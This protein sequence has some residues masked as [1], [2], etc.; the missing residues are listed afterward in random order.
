MESV[1]WSNNVER[2]VKGGVNESKQG[3]SSNR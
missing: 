1:N 2:G 3:Q